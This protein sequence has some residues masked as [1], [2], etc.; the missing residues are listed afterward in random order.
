MYVHDSGFYAEGGLSYG[1]AWNDYHADMLLGGR[2]TGK[3]GSNV[4][5]ADLEL[6]YIAHLGHEINLVPSV[7]IEYDYIQND[8]WTESVSGVPALTPNQFSSSHDHVLDIPV[9]IRAN[10]VVRFSE[11]SFMVPEIHAAYVYSANRARSSIQSGF[12]GAPG[13]MTMHGVNPGRSR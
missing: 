2:K 1:H 7:G 8:S 10:K 12:V 5:S 13:N 6:G 3:Y 4:F 11:T 9:G